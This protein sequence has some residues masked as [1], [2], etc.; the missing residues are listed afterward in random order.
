MRS[1][2]PADSSGLHQRLRPATDKYGE[3]LNLDMSSRQR[4]CFG[5]N[6]VEPAESREILADELYRGGSAYRRQLGGN[7]ALAVGPSFVPRELYLDAFP[8]VGRNSPSQRK[9]MNL[10]RPVVDPKR[11]DLLEDRCNGFHP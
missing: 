3:E 1:R 9:Q 4:M 7:S 2:W 8:P 11:A 5:C 6:S 10:G